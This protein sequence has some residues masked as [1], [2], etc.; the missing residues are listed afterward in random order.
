MQNHTNHVWVV[1]SSY[2]GGNKAYTVLARNSIVEIGEHRERSQPKHH[3]CMEK[4][5]DYTQNY[6]TMRLTLTWVSNKDYGKSY[7]LLATLV[8]LSVH[9]QEFASLSHFSFHIYVTLP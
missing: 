5:G 9:Q 4:A 2:T 6:L 7:V 3:L 1:P 8:K